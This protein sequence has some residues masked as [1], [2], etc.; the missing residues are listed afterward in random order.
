MAALLPA[1]RFVSALDVPTLL[2]L[3]LWFGAQLL[4]GVATLSEQTQT[5]GLLAWW[6]HAGGFVAGLI[7]V[8]LFRP[9]KGVPSYRY[10]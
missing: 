1:F 8:N 5:T 2:L 6:A 10:L 4:S 7:L 9:R 3:V